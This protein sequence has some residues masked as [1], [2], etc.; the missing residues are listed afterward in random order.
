M[1]VRFDLKLLE[2]L[3]APSPALAGRWL[4]FGCSA[5][6]AITQLDLRAMQMPGVR[7]LMKAGLA[8]VRCTSCGG[9]ADRVCGYV[10]S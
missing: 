1:P 9:T 3:M 6:N 5:C 7:L 2:R 8:G 4:A 10:I